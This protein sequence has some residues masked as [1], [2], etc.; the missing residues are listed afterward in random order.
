MLRL[1]GKGFEKLFAVLGR[2]CIDIDPAAFNRRFA[3]A[4]GWKK[5]FLDLN[6]L[7]DDLVGPRD[8]P[9]YGKGRAAWVLAFS[10]LWSALKW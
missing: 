5:F 9:G 10:L 7:R 3:E 8:L 2:T 1:G 4:E 6:H